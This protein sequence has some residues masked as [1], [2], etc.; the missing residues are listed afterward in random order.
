M[1]PDEGVFNRTLPYGYYR[2]LLRDEFKIYL[3]IFVQNFGGAITKYQGMKLVPQR[4][5]LI[6][7]PFKSYRISL[8]NR[9][10]TKSIL[11]E[12]I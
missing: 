1:V 7:G 2:I 4:V 8:S 10:I 6:G 3:F 11:E 5:F 9:F 12:V